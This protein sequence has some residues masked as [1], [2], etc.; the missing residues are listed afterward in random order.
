MNNSSTLPS[1]YNYNQTKARTHRPQNLT[2]NPQIYISQQRHYT[3]ASPPRKKSLHKSRINFAP[4]THRGFTSAR[5]TF[6]RFKPRT[7]AL[8]A[9][10]TACVM[11]ACLLMLCLS[12]GGRCR[13]LIHYTYMKKINPKK[14]RC[15]TRERPNA[16]EITR[17]PGRKR[18]YTVRR[19]KAYAARR[20]GLSWSI[21]AGA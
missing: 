16:R 20:E 2:A 19:D 14:A 10:D 3:N 5:L 4:R 21:S 1:R 8:K 17:A 18:E 15:A 13:Q 11:C 12:G 7:Y 9:R 6:S